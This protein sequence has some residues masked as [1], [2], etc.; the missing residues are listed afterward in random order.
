VERIE[1][2]TEFISSRPK[3]L[4]IYAFTESRKLKEKILKETSSGSVTFN[5]T[6]IQFICDGLPFGGVGG[7]GFGR[8]HGRY[9]FE[10]FSHE[11]SVLHRSL[12]MEMEAR[13]PPWNDFK[14]EFIRLAYGFD[15][16]GILLLMLGLRR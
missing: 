9:S 1:E 5:D 4:A 14:M 15:Y 10:A 13:Y 16:L 11:K 2:S 3:P 12:K 6:L 7:S 8:Y